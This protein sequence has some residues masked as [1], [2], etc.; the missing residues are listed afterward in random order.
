LLS[1]HDFYAAGT[2]DWKEMAASQ[3][4]KNSS[5]V[6][7]TGF[8]PLYSTVQQ[9]P[10]TAQGTQGGTQIPPDADLARLVAAWPALSEE[11]KKIIGSLLD[12]T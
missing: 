12:L 7:G 10:L 2:R 1:E 8:E 5:M 4:V 9:E 11:R 6:R 3:E